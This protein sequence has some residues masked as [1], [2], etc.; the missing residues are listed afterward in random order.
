MSRF[1]GRESEVEY[2][3]TERADNE[4]FQLRGVN[5]S[6]EALDTMVF[7][8]TPSGGTRVRY[9]ADFQFKGLAGKAAPL[10]S[11]VL[12]LAFKRLG[13]EAE[14]GMTEALDGLRS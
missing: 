8:E 5:P 4:R 11:P 6:V 2:T 12:W 13:D 7:S 10:L 14:K 1:L 9:D 3:V